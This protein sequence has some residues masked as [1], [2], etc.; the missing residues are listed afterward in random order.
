MKMNNKVL[1]EL[2]VPEI[3]EIYNLYVPI[4]KKIG[5][6]IILL[7]KSV[8]ELSN[9]IFQYDNY[10]SIYDSTSGDKYPINVL[11]RETNIRNGSKIILI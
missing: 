6:L 1:I 4:N 2:V 5:N 11:V 8:Q 9:G 10:T 3:D 7:S